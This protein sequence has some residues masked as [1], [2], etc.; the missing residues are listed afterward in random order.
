MNDAK[1]LTVLIVD[2][3]P[4]ARRGLR[5]R[6][7]RL[8]GIDI[9]GECES[10]SEAVA[11]IETLAPDVVLL[12][13]QMPELNGFD[14]I[15][16]VGV[17]R[18]PVTVFVTAYDEHAIKAFD[19]HALDY[20][21][22]PVDDER[23]ARAMGRAR[24]RV[25][26]RDARVREL[27]GVLASSPGREARIVL[28]DR[29]RVVVLDH[30]D[31]D[32]IS[33]EGDYVRVYAGGRGYLVRHTMLAMEARLDPRAFARI[34]RSGIVNVSRVRE[35]RTHGDRDYVVVLRDGTRLKMSRSYRDRLTLPP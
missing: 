29:G 20:L 2:D 6:L 32:W 9:V 10:G 1:P 35:I 8:E 4:L 3:E 27:G 34:H 13:V 15:E 19:A 11:A 18:M 24:S 23:F 12:D 17:D 7:E 5:V 33:A 28:H 31:V 21:L 25:A 30:A 22:K 14:V 16:A 26:E